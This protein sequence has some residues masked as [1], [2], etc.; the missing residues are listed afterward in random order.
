[1]SLFAPLVFPSGLSVRNRAFLAPLTNKQ[2]HDDGSLSDD[3][4]H[5]L[6]SRA[7]GGFGLIETCAGHVSRDG[8]NWPGQLGIFDDA[9]LPGLTRLAG[10]IRQR[11]PASIFQLFHGGG[12]AD[13][14][15][16]G[17]VPWGP[18][19]ADG[20]RAA[21][22][23]DLHRVIGDFAD[24]AV[25]A[26]TAGFDGV[27]VHAGHGYLFTAFL[28]TTVNRR[29]DAWGGPL[30]RRARLLRNTVRAIRARVDRAFTV[31]VRL[32][33]ENWGRATGLDLDESL[34]VARWLCEDGADFIHLSL[35]QALANSTKY[36][37]RHAL[38]LFRR[39][40]PRRVPILA[41]GSIWTLKEAETVLKSGADAVALGRAAIANPDWAHRAA[42]P[43]WEPRRP[44]ITIAELRASG[45]NPAFAEYMRSFAGFVAE[46]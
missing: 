38:P 28:S 19:D 10:A 5:W 46:A 27:E 39:A 33:P 8:Q 7:E 13:P 1:V 2:S 44:P 42:D 20:V 14:A 35:W 9:L 4:L 45:L 3:E 15:L 36:P 30:E 29:E 24:A 32:S 43:G 18:S 21:T 12:R 26:Q 40:V 6:C 41:A 25:R 34:S 31:G 17:V 22:E 16:T 23:D 37:D 11:G